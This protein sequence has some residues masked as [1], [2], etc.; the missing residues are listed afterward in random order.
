MT[1]LKFAIATVCLVAGGYLFAV[2]KPETFVAGMAVGIA[3]WWLYEVALR[4]EGER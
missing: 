2:T 1:S 3:V 4:M